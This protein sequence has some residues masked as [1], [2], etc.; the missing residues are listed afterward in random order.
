[1]QAI[2][3]AEAELIVQSSRKTI[4]PAIAAV[5]TSGLR[6]AQDVLQAWQAK[7]MWMREADGLFFRAE[8]LGPGPTDYLTSTPARRWGKPKRTS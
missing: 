8:Q 5:A 2:L 7:D 3:Q 1:M 4:E 6:Q